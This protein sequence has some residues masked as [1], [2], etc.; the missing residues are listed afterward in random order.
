MEIECLGFQK[1]S[2]KQVVW[3]YKMIKDGKNYLVMNNNGHVGVFLH[4]QKNELVESGLTESYEKRIATSLEKVPKKKLN[5]GRDEKDFWK[6]PLEYFPKYEVKLS[7]PVVP[8]IKNRTYTGDDVNDL[9]DAMS[10]RDI[11]NDSE[12]KFLKIT[13]DMADGEDG[14]LLKPLIGYKIKNTV[15][16]DHKNDGQMVEYNFTFKSPAGKITEFSTEM[17]LMVGWNVHETLKIK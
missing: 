3:C 11:I 15:D 7:K 5:I 9:L 2:I 12:N 17:C 13:E 16:G 10:E 8:V 6:A 14:Y 4:N 1:N